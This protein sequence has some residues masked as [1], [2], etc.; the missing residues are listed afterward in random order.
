M[1]VSIDEEGC[2]QV[3]PLYLHHYGG[4]YADLDFAA[5]RPA[6]ELLLLVQNSS[7][8]LGK[9]CGLA[10]PGSDCEAY[11][12]RLPNAFMASVP[13]HSFWMFAMHGI[14]R[15]IWQQGVDAPIAPAP[16][17]TGPAPL[18]WAHEAYLRYIQQVGYMSDVLILDKQIYP[19]SW[20][21]HHGQY[22]LGCC[23]DDENV[24]YNGAC[25]QS[26]FPEA[27]VISFW[28]ATWW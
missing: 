24:T 1:R 7:V 18:A 27:Y 9:D 22:S 21:E 2:L 13:R 16:T 19:F 5:I 23:F 12:Q 11:N 3:R 17:S 20:T 10:Q 15:G 25:C 6:D 26:Q 28:S 14:L 8:L 4:I